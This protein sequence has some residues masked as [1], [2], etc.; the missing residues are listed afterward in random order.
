MWPIA[1]DV[2]KENATNV[3]Y[4]ATKSINSL[5]ISCNTRKLTCLSTQAA[6]VVSIVMSRVSVICEFKF[7]YFLVPPIFKLP[8]YI[9]QLWANFRPPIKNLFG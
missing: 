1:R 8:Q 7:N 6:T 4:N 9:V 2:K 3:N 5:F